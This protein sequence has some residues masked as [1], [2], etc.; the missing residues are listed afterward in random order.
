VGYTPDLVVGVW[1]GNTDNSAMKGVT[2]VTGAAPIWHEIIEKASEGTPVK[3]F[4]RPA[5]VIEA[6]ICLDGGH[7]PSASCPANRRAKEVFKA[8]QGPL[9]ADENVENAARAND[10]NLVN[11]QSSPQGQTQSQIIISQPADGSSVA[12]GVLSIRG[13]VNPPGFQSYQVEWGDG[14]NPGKWKWISGPHLSP[15]VDNQIT[16][17]GIENTPAG[18]YTLRVTASTTSGTLVGYSHFDIAP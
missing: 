2:G 8:G 5:G 1:V 14:D 10:P 12:R 7:A 17:W 4:A 15:V 13:T 6:E 16:Q 3:D 18:R 11:V 9:P